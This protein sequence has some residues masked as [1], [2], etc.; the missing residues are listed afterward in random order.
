[1]MDV[2]RAGVVAFDWTLALL[3]AAV[4]GWCAL[5]LG[6]PLLA[7]AAALVGFALGLSTLR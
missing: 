7:A 4:T 2:E 1:M 3:V 5:R 6:I